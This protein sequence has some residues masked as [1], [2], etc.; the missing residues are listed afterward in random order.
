M[1]R[2]DGAKDKIVIKL[3]FMR[4]KF[5]KQDRLLLKLSMKDN[6]NSRNLK[7]KKL[8]ELIYKGINEVDNANGLKITKLNYDFIVD[9]LLINALMIK[10]TDAFIL[11][12]SDS[13]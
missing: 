3:N 6:L 10:I 13:A 11:Y 4:N 7:Y 1:I 2:I 5:N 9:S 8:F 12:L